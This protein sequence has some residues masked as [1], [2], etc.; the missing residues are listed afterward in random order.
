MQ[1]KP[2]DRYATP[3]CRQD[4]DAQHAFGN[5]TEWWRLAGLNPFEIAAELYAEYGGTGGKPRKR[6]AIKPK[7]A[8]AERTVSHFLAK[9]KI[10]ARANPWAKKKF[11]GK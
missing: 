6:T 1:M 10:E 11:E 5:E 8:N 2:D 9:R 4:H 3:L 7:L